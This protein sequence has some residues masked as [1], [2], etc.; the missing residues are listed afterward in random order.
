MSKVPKTFDELLAV[1]ATLNDAGVV[2]I[3]FGNQFPWAA[4]H[5]I[6]EIIAKLVPGDVRTAD[7]A[8]TRPADEL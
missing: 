3:S 8:L 4:S 2:P 6:G 5:Y 7:Y 1:C